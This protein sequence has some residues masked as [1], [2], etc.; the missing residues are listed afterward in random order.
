MENFLLK[1]KSSQFFFHS[2]IKTSL[3]FD[4]K[5]L[6]VVC[7]LSNLWEE[8]HNKLCVSTPFGI[9]LRDLLDL[10]ELVDLS[11]FELSGRFFRGENQGLLDL[12]LLSFSIELKAAPLPLFVN[13]SFWLIEEGLVKPWVMNWW[14][15]LLKWSGASI[16]TIWP[17]SSTISSLLF[18]ITCKHKAMLF[19]KS[20][21]LFQAPGSWKIR[22]MVALTPRVLLFVSLHHNMAN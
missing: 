4:T 3:Y 17:V 19:K 15:I 14:T 21:C 18:T 8:T 7:S 22:L 10:M 20:Q 11:L 9:D 16:I 2:K 12:E 6:K 13:S 5:L 1:L